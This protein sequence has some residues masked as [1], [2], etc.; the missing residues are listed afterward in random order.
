MRVSKIFL[1]KEGTKAARPVVSP[2]SL[3][4]DTACNRVCRVLSLQS[5]HTVQHIPYVLE[6]LRFDKLSH[7][8][9]INNNISYK[10]YKYIHIHIGHKTFCLLAR[11]SLLYNV[12]QNI[13]YSPL[14]LY[15]SEQR[16]I[17]K[18]P[19]FCSAAKKVTPQLQHCCNTTLS[20][21][22]RIENF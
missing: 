6:R 12:L 3:H 17:A 9:N 18:K 1:A 8:I 10:K 5:E 20:F 21:L 15:S 19:K 16:V 22:L 7:T 11:S 13:I 4:T 2:Y 14:K